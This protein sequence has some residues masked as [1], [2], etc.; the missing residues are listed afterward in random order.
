MTWLYHYKNA[1]R[2]CI[3]G[4]VVRPVIRQHSN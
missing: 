3:D 1:N 2:L 4:G